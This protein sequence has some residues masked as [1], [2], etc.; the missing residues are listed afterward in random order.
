MRKDSNLAELD[1]WEWRGRKVDGFVRPLGVDSRRSCDRLGI[2]EKTNK[3]LRQD[4]FEL[5]TGQYELNIFNT[6]LRTCKP[7]TFSTADLRNVGRK[8][9]EGIRILAPSSTSKVRG[10][11][12]GQS[13]KAI[14]ICLANVRTGLEELLDTKKTRRGRP[15]EKVRITRV[16]FH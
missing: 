3:N 14:K 16:G 1:K 15:K 10:G 2:Y 8:T 5:L 7:F 13:Q 6:M 4:M 11:G 12:D 9:R